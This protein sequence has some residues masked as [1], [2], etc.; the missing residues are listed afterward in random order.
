MKEIDIS[1]EEAR[2]YTY[3]QGSMP[4]SLQIDYPARLFI[5]EGAGHRVMD[6]YGWVHYI[7]AGWCHLKWKPKPGFA[8]VVA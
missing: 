5:T 6:T 1:C 3:P 2:V 8:P 4:K 7:P